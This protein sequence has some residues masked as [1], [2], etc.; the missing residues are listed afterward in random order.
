MVLLE[1]MVWDNSWLVG[2][3]LGTEKKLKAFRKISI[4]KTFFFYQIL[5]HMP[6]V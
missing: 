5:Q 1:E 3:Y 6:M 2:N 4:V